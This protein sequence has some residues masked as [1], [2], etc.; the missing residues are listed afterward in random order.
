MDLVVADHVQRVLKTNF[1]ASWEEVGDEFEMSD[2]YA[3]TQ[4]NSL[5]GTFVLSPIDGCFAQSSVKRR[6]FS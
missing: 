5:E 3:L 4:M 6:V 1:L 2:T